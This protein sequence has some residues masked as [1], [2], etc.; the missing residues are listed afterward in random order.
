MTSGV[1]YDRPWEF[2]RAGSH[3]YLPH[4]RVGAAPAPLVCSLSS[5]VERSRLKWFGG[6]SSLEVTPILCVIEN[7]VMVC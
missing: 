5:S 1:Q 6:V 3:R 4:C 2:L 7:C